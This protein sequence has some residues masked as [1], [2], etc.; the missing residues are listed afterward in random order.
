LLLK[1]DVKRAAAEGLSLRM[2]LQYQTPDSGDS[3]QETT[4]SN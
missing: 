3:R 2:L 4:D 1:E